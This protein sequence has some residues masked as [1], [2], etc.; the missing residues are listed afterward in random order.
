MSNL[1]NC[2]NF[3]KD[4]MHAPQSDK[5]TIMMIKYAHV[6]FNLLCKPKK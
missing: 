5:D 2:N 3:Q 1:E 6:K 4:Q